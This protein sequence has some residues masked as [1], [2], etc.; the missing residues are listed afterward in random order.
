MLLELNACH[1]WELLALLMINLLVSKEN[2][3]A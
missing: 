1:F 3:M 2:A